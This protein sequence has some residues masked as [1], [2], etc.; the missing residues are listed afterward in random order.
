W[1]LLAARFHQRS[2]GLLLAD[3]ARRSAL[4]PTASTRLRM[5]P[6]VAAA[7]PPPTLRRR[8]TKSAAP[9]AGQILLWYRVILPLLPAAAAMGQGRPPP[10]RLRF[11]PR[12]SAAPGT[13]GR[14]VCLALLPRHIAN[15]RAS[16]KFQVSSLGLA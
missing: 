13:P 1:S 3:K 12:G 8:S 14:K 15:K 16:H 10:A 5:A 11:A 9:V 7:S 6:V 2:S 4:L